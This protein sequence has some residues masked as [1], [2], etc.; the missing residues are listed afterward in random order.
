M[1][2]LPNTAQIDVGTFAYCGITDVQSHLL[3]DV[4][5]PDAAP[6]RAE[7]LTDV[8]IVAEQFLDPNRKVRNAKQDHLDRRHA[9]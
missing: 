1:S 8:R 3:Y 4:E 2:L 5:G 9:A 7:Q 6:Q